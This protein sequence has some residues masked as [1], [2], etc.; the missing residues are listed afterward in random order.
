MDKKGIERA[1][2]HIK[3]SFIWMNSEMGWEYWNDVIIAL[4]NELEDEA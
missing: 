4:E 1:I 3:S 2:Y